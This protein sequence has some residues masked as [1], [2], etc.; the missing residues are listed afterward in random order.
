[1]FIVVVVACVHIIVVDFCV[2]G[3][4]DETKQSIIHIPYKKFNHNFGMWSLMYASCYKQNILYVEHTCKFHDYMK[5][6]LCIVHC[7][8]SFF[9]NFFLLPPYF[10]L[11]LYENHITCKNIWA[12]IY[13]YFVSINIQISV[14]YGL[15]HTFRVGWIFQLNAY[16]RCVWRQIPSTNVYEFFVRW[17]LSKVAAKMVER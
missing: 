3:E 6:W 16:R 5:M 9:L 11:V 17:T 12:R 4:G 14:C 7:C 10:F 8:C 2:C 15:R 1:M 13:R